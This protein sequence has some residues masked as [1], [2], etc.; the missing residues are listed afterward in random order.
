MRGTKVNT[1]KINALLVS[2]LA[3]S[4][5]ACGSD[6]PPSQ[7]TRDSAVETGVDATTDTTPPTDNPPPQD[8]PPPGSFAVAA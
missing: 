5:V 8:N 7:S 3:A 2:L 4:A 6:P 1:M